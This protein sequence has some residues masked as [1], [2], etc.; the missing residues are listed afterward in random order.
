M[1]PPGFGTTGGLYAGRFS[2]RRLNCGELLTC[3]MVVRSYLKKKEKWLR[4]AIVNQLVHP[5][6][7]AGRHRQD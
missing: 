1:E 3:W 5:A 6:E 7:R 2:Y 4:D